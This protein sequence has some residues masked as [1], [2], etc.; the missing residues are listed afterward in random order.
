M[1]EVRSEPEPEAP[2]VKETNGFKIIQHIVADHF[3]LTMA[4]FLMHRRMLRIARPRQIAMYLC[5][6]LLKRSY[7][8]IGRR[9][10]GR[11]HTTV[12]SAMW[13]IEEM[14]AADPVFSATV[15]E[16]KETARG[17]LDGRG[18]DL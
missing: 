9:F 13:K 6:E 4:E 11:D 17:E 7:P 2:T 3:G 8:E 15:A 14:M 18:H 1:A 12:L 16:L 5:R 10:G